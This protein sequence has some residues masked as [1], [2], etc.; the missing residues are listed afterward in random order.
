[1]DSARFGV[2]SLC[3]FEQMTRS[4]SLGI[5]NFKDEG[6]YLR[7]LGREALI[8]S[9][10]GFVGGCRAGNGPSMGKQA[11]YHGTNHGLTTSLA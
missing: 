3:G 7:V 9:S 6:T 5:F 2:E 10:L 1:M 8:H 4:I 11:L